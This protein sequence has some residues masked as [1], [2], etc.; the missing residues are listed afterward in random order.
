[1]TFRYCPKCGAPLREGQDFCMRCGCDLNEWDQRLAGNAT[2]EDEVEDFSEVDL[3]QAAHRPRHARVEASATEAEGEDPEA[4]PEEWQAEPL[5]HGAGNESP[6]GGPLAEEVGPTPQA[7]AEQAPEDEPRPK[8]P[9][10]PRSKPTS[11]P[12]AQEHADAATRIVSPLPVTIHD[13]KLYEEDAPHSRRKLVLFV[14]VV[15]VGIVAFLVS[16]HFHV[17]VDFFDPQQATVEA[18]SVDGSSGQADTEAQKESPYKDVPGYESVKALYED[19]EDLDKQVTDCEETFDKDFT[20][21]KATRTQDSK[22]ASTLAKTLAAAQ[23]EAEAVD[24]AEDSDLYGQYQLVL[25][26]YQNLVDRME[27][28]TTAWDQDLH[29]NHPESY[30]EKLRSPITKQIRSGET[31]VAPKVDYQ[32]NYRQIDL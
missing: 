13:P 21:D 27:I 10:G 12:A 20:T 11:A 6:D 15:I 4:S 19:L 17:N 30:V 25:S 5:T 3:S 8:S 32:A 2:P 16:F 23:K 18:N 28:I 26:C 29:Y 7:R 22:V 24:V 31:E 9:A 1:M 14:S